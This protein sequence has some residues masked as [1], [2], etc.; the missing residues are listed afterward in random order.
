MESPV[1][2]LNYKPYSFF[3]IAGMVLRILG[4]KFLGD[5]SLSKIARHDGYICSE[6]VADSYAHAG[7]KVLNKPHSIVTPG[8][9]AERLIYQ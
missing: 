6:L 8:D 9:L 7:F 3:T 2:L 4:F 5:K 1:F